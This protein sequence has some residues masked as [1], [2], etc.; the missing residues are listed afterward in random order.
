MSYINNVSHIIYVTHIISV[1]HINNVAQIFNDGK[2]GRIIRVSANKSYEI[3]LDAK[4]TVE[5]SLKHSPTH[6]R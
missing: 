5:T 3:L 6:V 2:S 1:P 4:T